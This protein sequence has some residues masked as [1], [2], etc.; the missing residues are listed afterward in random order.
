MTRAQPQDM[1]SEDYKDE[2]SAGMI[3][4]RG[5]LFE[6]TF[7]GSRGRSRYGKESGER[8][9]EESGEGFGERDG[10]ESGEGD[11]ERDGEEAGEG[12]S[13][14]LKRE[15]QNPNGF[16]NGNVNATAQSG[17]FPLAMAMCE[18]E[19]GNEFKQ[20]PNGQNENSSTYNWGNSG[21][22]WE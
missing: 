22:I 14:E 7:G 17:S 3:N 16:Y 5:W 2:W 9:G 15:K 19:H 11:E 21:N 12:F 20:N 8:D 18:Y 13:E 1:G 10:E 4:F 6:L